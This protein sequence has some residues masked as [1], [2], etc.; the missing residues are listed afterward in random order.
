MTQVRTVTFTNVQDNVERTVEFPDINKAMQFVNILHI[1]GV[2]AIVNL[3][4][5][6]VAVWYQQLLPHEYKLGTTQFTTLFFFIM[7]KSVMIS[8]LAQGNTG[9]EILQI[10][11]TLTEDNQQAVAYAEPTADSIEFW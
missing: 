3:L 5:E 1:G 8:L 4:P 9:S 2:D 11:D 6:D 7:S 10:L